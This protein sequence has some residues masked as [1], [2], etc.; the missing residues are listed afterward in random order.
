MQ[1]VKSLDSMFGM[2]LFATEVLNT[3]CLM[4]SSAISDNF[5][6]ILPNHKLFN[7]FLNAFDFLTFLDITNSLSIFL[8]VS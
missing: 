3:H 6:N 8:T 2:L 4:D 5:R 7:V 1:L